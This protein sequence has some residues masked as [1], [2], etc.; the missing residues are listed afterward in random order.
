M[1]EPAYTI[2]IQFEANLPGPDEIA[3]AHLEKAAAQTLEIAGAAAGAALSIQVSTND[4]VR[5]LNFQY[6]GVDAPTDVLSFPS[7]PLP[8]EVEEDRGYLGDI[9]IA[10]PYI[11]Q[12]AQEEGRSLS[13]DLALMIIHGT[14]HLLGYDHDNAEAQ[15]EMW[16]LQQ[17]ALQALGISLHV[18][19]Y[20]HE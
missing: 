14:L 9:I 10:L 16:Q 19:D 4:Q 17:Q 13:D 12:R 6:R 20:L 1:T 5:R 11:V 15:A 8:E 18:P 7:E 2:L 3:P